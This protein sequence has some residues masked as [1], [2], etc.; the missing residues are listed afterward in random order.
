MK[1]DRFFRALL[2]TSLVTFSWFGMMAVHELGHVLHAWVSGGT[3][4]RVVLH[5]AQFSRTDVSPNPR[6][7]MVAWGGA[8]WGCV[9]PLLVW[10]MAR[11]V[12][13]KHMHLAVFFAGFC[14]IAN[15]AYLA[16]G[17]FVLAGDAGDLLAH[18]AARWQL[19]CF[20]VVATAAGLYLWNGLGPQ[21][22][23]GLSARPVDRKAA[24][25]IALVV[26]LLLAAEIKWG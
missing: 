4:V 12:A 21:F 3:V 23:W 22:G 13:P 11:H 6:P 1:A 26:S 16:A 5:P 9:I 2:I 10:A 17:A 19:V 7:L 15:G 20:G 25:L 14:L 18:G 8:I 24:V